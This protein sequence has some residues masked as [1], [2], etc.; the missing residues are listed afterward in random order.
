MA[1]R[2][3]AEGADGPTQ[4]KTL[5]PLVGEGLRAV[6][7]V[8]PIVETQVPVRGVVVGRMGTGVTHVSLDVHDLSFQ[9]KSLQDL[10]QHISH[11]AYSEFEKLIHED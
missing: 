2:L 7:A 3:T 5:Q 6:G 11:E 9:L 1:D 4:Q 8:A 10:K